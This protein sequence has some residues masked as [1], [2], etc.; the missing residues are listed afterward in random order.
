ME[1]I[2]DNSKFIASSPTYGLDYRGDDAIHL[3][4]IGSKLLGSYQGLSVG[5]L[6]DGVINKGLTFT[7]SLNANQITLSFGKEIVIDIS[8]IGAVTNYG[9]SVIKSDNTNLISSVDITDIVNGNIKINCTE[10]PIGAKLRYGC[11]N[12]TTGSGK[13][14]GPRGN[15]RGKQ[16]LL[17]TVNILGVIYPLHDWLPIFEKTL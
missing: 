4:N 3:S 15:V 6:I 11:V 5:N 7:T 1:L 17:Y 13:T 12:V 16:G 8:N 9:F 14:N 2:R 10:S